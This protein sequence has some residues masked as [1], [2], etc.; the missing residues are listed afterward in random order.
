MRGEP[1]VNGKFG[2][3]PSFPFFSGLCFHGER[4]AP[5]LSLVCVPADP[6]YTTCLLW[7][8]F[9]STTQTS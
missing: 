4:R 3:V 9:P 1:N 5:P 8:H 6:A 7:F 2:T